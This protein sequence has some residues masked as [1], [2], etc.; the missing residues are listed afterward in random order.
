MVK[1]FYLTHRWDL[2]WK[3]GQDFDIALADKNN[4]T[5]IMNEF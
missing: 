2:V 3:E 5:F 1:Q 4:E